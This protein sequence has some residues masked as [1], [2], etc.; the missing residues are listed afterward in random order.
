MHSII[1]NLSGQEL[2]T[3]E[4]SRTQPF[5]LRVKCKEAR[6][7]CHQLSGNMANITEGNL[8]KM[9]TKFNNVD[10]FRDVCKN[11]IWTS[12]I[13]SIVMIKQILN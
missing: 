10:K 5:Q 6:N 1:I 2:Y 9:L 7:I 11:K 3:D 12:V 8:D 4:V 13:S